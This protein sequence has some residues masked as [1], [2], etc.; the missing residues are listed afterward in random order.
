M[1]KIEKIT[2]MFNNVSLENYPFLKTIDKFESINQSDISTCPNN[3]HIPI[4][5]THNE[6]IVVLYDK[7]PINAKVSSNILTNI[8]LSILEE[9]ASETFYFNYAIFGNNNKIENLTKNSFN[10]ESILSEY[11]NKNDSDFR[12]FTKMFVRRDFAN[13]SSSSTLPLGKIDPDTDKPFPKLR[14]VSE[15]LQNSVVHKLKVRGRYGFQKFLQNKEVAEEIVDGDV[16][17]YTLCASSDLIAYVNE[18]NLYN[19]LLS[20]Y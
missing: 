16:I 20:E 6:Y 14:N 3:S 11:V 15:E 5:T 7:N 9:K 18:L 1:N 13:T 12:K 8:L 2:N 17:Q 4:R 19:K 10:D